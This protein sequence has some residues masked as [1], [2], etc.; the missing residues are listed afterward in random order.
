MRLIPAIDLRN[1]V[2]VRLFKGD[3]DQETRY[4]VEP[5]ALARR[6]LELGARW[7]H[8]VDLDGA[9]NGEPI[10]RTAVEAIARQ[11]QLRIQLGGGIRTEA[12]LRAALGIAHRAV[13]GSLAIADPEQ[14]ANWLERYGADRLVLALDVRLDSRKV[15][16]VTTHGWRT[17]SE[18]SLWDVLAAYRDTTLKHVL[19]TDIDRDGALQGANTELYAICTERYPQFEWQA[20]GGVRGPEDLEAL[21]ACKAAAAV[22]GKSLL[23]G[24]FSDEEMRAFFAKE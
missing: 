10:N 8:V 1:G 12:I 22:A 17:A 5:G 18:Q 11:G 13:I 21:A 4:P 19:C 23:E 2:C 6:Y 3:F 9:A 24:R 14:V 7:L 16:R 20:S 15:P